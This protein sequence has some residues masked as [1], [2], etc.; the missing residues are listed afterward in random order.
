LVYCL[1]RSVNEYV[2]QIDCDTLAVG[3]DVD[4]VVAC[5]V[6]NRSF[7]M[8]DGFPRMTLPEAVELANATPSDYIGMVVE[9]AFDSYPGAK[10]LHYVR[11]SAGFAGFAKG[12]TTRALI[13]EFHEVMERLLGAK[14]WREW[15][16]EQCGSNFAIANSPDPVVLPFPQYAS[17]KPRVLRHE[18]KLFHFIGRFRYLDGY[19]AQRGQEVIAGLTPGA[20]LQA[21]PAP[22]VLT[23]GDDRLP[24][25]F[26]R[27]LSRHDMLPYLWWKLSGRRGTI[28]V[29]MAAR[30]EFR[31]DPDPGPKFY[32]RGA[33]SGNNDSGVA[34]EVFVHMYYC[35]PVWIPP[36]RVKLVVDLGA[37]V[38]ISC[39]WW[40]ANYW[41]ADVIAFEPHPGHAA[42]ARANIALNGYQSRIELHQSA[43]GPAAMKA[44]ISDDGAASALSD[45]GA[46]GFE[47]DVVDFFVE[48][49][50]RRVDILKL[51]IEGSEVALL[52]D[53]RFATFDVG[54]LGMEWHRPDATGRGG[55]DWCI[56]RLCELGFAVYVTADHGE[57]GILWAYRNG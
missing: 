33:G 32:L 21:P 26:V 53:P 29:Q 30:R 34:Y 2:I 20:A 23:T 4:E 25:L 31:S 16:T 40:L 9:R 46:S 24:M 50:G 11:G 12:G 52:D 13:S 27:S 45:Q 28:A 56:H 39:L 37:N 49:A 6:A 10:S 18:V 41:R 44:F 7:T 1:D 5:V 3:E 51:D 48:L 57:Q 35:P 42:Q 38:G 54:A 55:R 14:R 17:F 22:T 8:S 36:E 15:G 43:V 47:V 19:Y